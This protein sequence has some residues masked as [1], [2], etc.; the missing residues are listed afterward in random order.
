VVSV[1]VFCVVLFVLAPIW[2]PITTLRTGGGA[3]CIGANGP[4]P[5]VGRSVTWCRARVP[6]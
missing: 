3:L 2:A 1:I 6:A 5:R 4:R